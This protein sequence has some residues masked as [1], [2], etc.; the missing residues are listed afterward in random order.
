MRNLVELEGYQLMSSHKR[1]EGEFIARKFDAAGLPCIVVELV[2]ASKNGVRVARPR[3][4]VAARRLLPEPERGWRNTELG[5]Y[6]IFGPAEEGLFS[7]ARGVVS[8]RKATFGSSKVRVEY[9]RLFRGFAKMLNSDR[10]EV[11][12]EGCARLTHGGVDHLLH[13]QRVRTDG[14]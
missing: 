11:I 8:R 2:G 9:A 6:S 3:H 14:F 13:Q 10:I 5:R 1:D 7:N 12:Q 4:N